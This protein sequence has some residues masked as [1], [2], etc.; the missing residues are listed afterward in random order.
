MARKM[1]YR[2]ERTEQLFDELRH[3]NGFVSKYDDVFCGEAYL[4]AIQKGQ[5][6]PDDTLLMF[7]IDGA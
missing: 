4:D 2:A 5:I 1:C 3:N 6:G 7:S